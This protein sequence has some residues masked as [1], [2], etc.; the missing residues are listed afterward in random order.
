MS[1]ESSISKI[2]YVLC[3]LPVCERNKNVYFF[4]SLV[5]LSVTTSLLMTW[6]LSTFV[7]S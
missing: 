3:V 2:R 5:G 4:S 1:L 6:Q 7:K